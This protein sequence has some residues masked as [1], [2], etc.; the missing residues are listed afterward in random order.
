VTRHKDSPSRRRKDYRP[1]AVPKHPLV[2]VDLP[3]ADF[4]A[5][6]RRRLALDAAA[7]AKAAFD[8]GLPL[9][10]QWFDTYDPLY[11]LSFCAV[12]F[13]SSEQGV[14]REAIDGFVD[15]GSHHLELLQAFALLQ[16]RRGTPAPLA[17]RATELRDT[18]NE[19]THN[20]SLS[21][22]L[23]L[24]KASSDTDLKKHMVINQMRIQTLAIRN[25]DYP[26]QAIAHLKALYAGAL[27]EVFQREL[28]ISA[29]RLI[30]A[31]VALVD[32]ITDRLNE[33]VRRLGPVL[34]AK[35][36]SRVRTAYLEAFPMVD[37]SSKQMLGI[38][39]DICGSDLKNFK[40]FLLAHSD[41]FLEYIFSLSP[42][43]LKQSCGDDISASDLS[44]VWD[45]WSLDFGALATRNPYHFLYSNPVLAQPFIKLDGG[46][47]FW[48]L[49]GILTHT[50]PEM[51][52]LL[53]PASER[54]KYLI[55]RSVYLEDA[56]E[57]LCRRAFPNAGVYR[58]SQWY[59]SVD[60]STV[61]ENDVLV[62][63]DSVVLVI[64]CKAHL[65]DPPARRGAELRLI[66]TLNDLVVSASHQAHRFC[67]LLSTQ[68]KVHQ[69]ATK[70]GD[71][72]VV[73]VSR[74]VRFIPISVTYENLGFVS[75]NLKT[76][77]QAGLIDNGHSP[78]VSLCLSDLEI[79]FEILDSQAQRIH[80]LS[81][82]AEIERSM[83]Y[84]G[85]EMDLLAFYV[86]T[87]FNIGK[88]EE[89]AVFL[90]LT[91]KSAEL[92]PYFVGRADGV[93]VP[94]PQLKLTAWW[95]DILL[96]VERRRQEFWTEI[97]YALLS[98]GYDD[99]VKFEE[100]FNELLER[101][102]NGEV[103]S[104]HNWIE[105]LSG[106][107]AKRQYV[108]AAYPYIEVSRAERNRM[109]RHIAAQSEGEQ[110]VSGIVILGFDLGDPSF[111]YDVLAYV[112]GHSDDAPP[113]LHLLGSQDGE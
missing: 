90:G 66:D 98:V 101:V 7:D 36:F 3:L 105:L 8:A 4:S 104:R 18:L 56:V 80:Y 73:D 52:Q 37:D 64:E 28:R 103:T 57:A 79:A 96:R 15:F 10:S 2:R 44:R 62:V 22:L 55:R 91:M 23:D 81:R 102:V 67:D 92:D 20:L 50:L 39:N 38:Y 89:G 99:Q 40:Q 32:L 86:E 94:K 74:V 78:I 60:E 35:S 42:D 13:L 69:F 41:L 61:Y 85:D 31:L 25:W 46:C 113:I 45:R 26:D 5:A 34:R 48:V 68:P 111:P 112:P 93:S 88:A 71:L 27:D 58:G 33:H 63:L 12:Y 49:G 16:A 107:N 11:V 72:N 76:A 100:W 30:D 110:K 106:L 54:P 43:D 9:L 70:R 6:E 47:S 87:G 109:I 29:T 83:N 97:A 1:Y 21:H 59:D 19:L 53:I 77:V 14:N 65:V 108:V 95:R 84:S 82:R 17:A 75:A 51:L 24:D